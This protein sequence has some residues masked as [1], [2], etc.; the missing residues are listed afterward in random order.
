MHNESGGWRERLGLAVVPLG[1]MISGKDISLEL[2]SDDLKAEGWPE[3]E[4][5][6]RQD[7]NLQ[8]GPS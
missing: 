5:K 2:P 4:G 6:N 8:T 1:S 7:I 3:I